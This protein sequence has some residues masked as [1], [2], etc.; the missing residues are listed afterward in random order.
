MGISEI[1]FILFMVLIL[2]GADKLP[3]VARGLGKTMRQL[4]DATDEIKTEIHHHINHTGIDTSIVED[5][6]KEIEELK[7]TIDN[8]ELTMKNWQWIMNN[9]LILSQRCEPHRQ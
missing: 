6:Q 5:T 8:E 2:F 4:R 9:K 3:E 1:I 7:K